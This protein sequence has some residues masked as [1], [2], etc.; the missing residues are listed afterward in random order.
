MPAPV[1]SPMRRR[2]L[3]PLLSA[4]RTLPSAPAS[5]RYR[6][7]TALTAPS[8]PAPEKR[9]GRH[10]DAVHPSTVRKMPD[11]TESPTQPPPKAASVHNICDPAC[12]KNL[13]LNKKANNGNARSPNVRNPGTG[14]QITAMW[15]AVIARSAKYLRAEALRWRRVKTALSIP[16]DFSFCFSLIRSFIALSSLRFLSILSLF[17]QIILN[18]SPAV[19]PHFSIPFFSISPIFPFSFS[20]LSPH[21]FS[22]FSLIK[23]SSFSL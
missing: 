11:H 14:L 15:S 10:S 18:I 1:P 20:T 9:S 13:L 3:P 23:K 12:E 22:L 17:H 4:Y 2:L 6:F 5:P 7:H 8:Q 21:L 19:H 16:S